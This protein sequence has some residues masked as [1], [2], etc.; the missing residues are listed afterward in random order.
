MSQTISGDF[1][2]IQQKSKAF[3]TGATKKALKESYKYYKIQSYRSYAAV[4]ILF[5]RKERLTTE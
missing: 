3:L 2:A 5:Y 1:T 4:E